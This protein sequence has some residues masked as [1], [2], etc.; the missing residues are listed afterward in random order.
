MRA[1][2]D[3]QERL[4]LLTSGLPEQREPPQHG[5]GSASPAPLLD[6]LNSD[7]LDRVVSLLPP[8][9][10]ASGL[11]LTCR[12]A[13]ARFRQPATKTVHLSQLVNAQFFAAHWSN[14]EAWRCLSLRQR[15][16]LLCL[17]ASSGEL[18]NLALVCDRADCPLT[19]DVLCAAA[20]SG[21][22]DTCRWLRT[23]R[24]CPWDASIWCAAAE[25]GSLAV[26]E[27]LLQQQ[28]QHKPEQA[29][30]KQSTLVWDDSAL[31]AAS[32][33]GHLHVCRWLLAHGCPW[34]ES[35]PGHAA[36]Q[37]HVSVTDALLAHAAAHSPPLH[38]H[39]HHLLCGAAQGC[40]L[41]DLQR[42]LA[43]RL[44]SGEAADSLSD[45][46]REEVVAAAAASSTPDWQA[47]VTWLLSCPTTPASEDDVLAR[48]GGEGGCHAGPGY[49]RNL[50]AES[51]LE[52]GDLIKVPAAARRLAW[53][54][55]QFGVAWP[56]QELAHAAALAGDTETLSYII[57][58]AGGTA[59]TLYGGLAHEAAREGHLGV[60]RLLRDRGCCVEGAVCAAARGGHLEVVR[61][62][63]EEGCGT[64]QQRVG[65]GDGGKEHVLRFCDVVLGFC[66][67]AHSAHHQLLLVA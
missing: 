29:Q 28:E 54:Q 39:L 59:R 19:P 1:R 51:W 36:C 13:A 63:L 24:A 11:R 48:A 38:V 31:V 46:E 50:C 34:H 37:G 23:A 47:K 5:L 66:P 3:S 45:R 44:P 41:P 52:W 42:Y 65:A 67:L 53:L 49:P 22:L 56:R 26:C 30:G 58:A 64:E 14:S 33:K 40:S 25:G 4:C 2:N 60:L 6:I 43:T 10:V 62:L 20:R 15:Q 27:W 12:G 9:D 61:W 55:Q 21:Q 17:V 32:A 18:P 8:N 35:A 7:I 16:Q 57:E